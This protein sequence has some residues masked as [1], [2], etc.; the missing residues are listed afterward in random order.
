M[1]NRVEVEIQLH[2][3]LSLGLD[4][5]GGQRHAPSALSPGKSH[6]TYFTG[7]WVVLRICLDGYIEERQ[8]LTPTELRISNHQ[9]RS[10]SLYRVS[11]PGSEVR[12]HPYV[13]QKKI[14][15]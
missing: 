1:G 8:S 9:A 7:I 13:F 5:V 15:N 12:L 6:I 11:N 3:F 14:N 4:G 2:S 10:E